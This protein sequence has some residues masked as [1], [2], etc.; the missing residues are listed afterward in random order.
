MVSDVAVRQDGPVSCCDRALISGFLS[1]GYCPIILMT[2]P[3]N[4]LAGY[5]VDY[6]KSRSHSDISS[7]MPSSAVSTPDDGV[8]VWPPAKSSAACCAVA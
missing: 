7:G 2:R 3:E 4:I 1:R 6:Q 5:V 8:K